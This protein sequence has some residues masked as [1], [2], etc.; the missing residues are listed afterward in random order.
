MKMKDFILP[1]GVL[2]GLIVL[3]TLILITPVTTNTKAEPEKS[4]YSEVCV[5]GV[6]YISIR[7]S[8]SVKFNTDSTVVLC[9]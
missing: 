8:L 3:L 7:S 9:Y 6:T 2:G 1:I 4:W 5:E